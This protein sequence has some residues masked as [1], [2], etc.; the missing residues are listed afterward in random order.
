MT[1]SKLFEKQ[2]LINNDEGINNI[3]I[4]VIEE[5]IVVD[6]KIE[7]TGKLKISK[8]VV[9]NIETVNIP[10]LHNEHYIEHKEINVLVDDLPSIRHEGDTIIIPVIKE[11]LVKRILLVEEIRITQRTLETNEQQQIKLRKENVTVERSSQ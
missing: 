5:H 11:V 10:L 7:E 1:N 2:N 3:N 4:P 9:E 8:H 6:K